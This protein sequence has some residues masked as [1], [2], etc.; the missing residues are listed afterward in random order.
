MTAGRRMYRWILRGVRVI[1]EI[2]RNIS[3][4]TNNNQTINKS[5]LNSR[6]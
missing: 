5:P 4:V 2:I 6:Y 1:I 3:S